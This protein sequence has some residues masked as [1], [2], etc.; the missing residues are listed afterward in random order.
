MYIV[1]TNITIQ[2]GAAMSTTYEA[3][4]KQATTT[5]TNMTVRGLSEPHMLTI[6]CKRIAVLLLKGADKLDTTLVR[7]LTNHMVSTAY[8]VTETL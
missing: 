5:I 7:R 6:T 8:D 4:E 2:G 3:L 1:R